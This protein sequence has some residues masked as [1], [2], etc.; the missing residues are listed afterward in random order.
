MKNYYVIVVFIVLVAVSADARDWRTQLNISPPQRGDRQIPYLQFDWQNSN[1]SRSI[2]TQAMR[3]FFDGLSTHPY[4]SYTINFNRSFVRDK[5]SEGRRVLR[6]F[7]IVGPALGLPMFNHEYR[8]TVHKRLYDFYGNFVHEVIRSENYTIH[9]NIY[10][11]S[12][13]GPTPREIP[14]ISGIF[15]RLVSQARA[16]LNHHAYAITRQ[17]NASFFQRPFDEL[18]TNLRNGTRIA[19]LPFAG[20]NYTENTRVMSELTRYLLGSNRQ[21]YVVDRLHT[22]SVIR[23][24]GFQAMHHLID[25]NTRVPL[26]RL[27]GAQVLIV[28]SVQTINNGKMLTLEAID[29]ESGRVFGASSLVY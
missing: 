11:E 19:V 27:M 10:Q 1:V 2:A 12:S 5:V 29:V 6:S 25:E 4:G 3:G 28:G 21:L 15:S 16:E 13:S 23:E 24:I 18:T 9:L 26:G 14:I 20:P 17:L 22:Q 7:T 8:L